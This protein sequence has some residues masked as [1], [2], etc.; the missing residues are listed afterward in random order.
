VSGSTWSYALDAT[1]LEAMGQGPATLTATATDAAGN[2]SVATSQSIAVDT[3]A[4]VVKGTAT[5]SGADSAG[6]AKATS[7]T[8]GDLLLVS[9]DMSEDVSVSSSPTYTITLDDGTTRTATYDAALSGSAELVFSYAVQASDIDL[10]GGVTA[11]ANALVASAIDSAGNAAN[12]AVAAIEDGANTVQIDTIAASVTNA[13]L[14]DGLVT[15]LDVSSNIVLT[16]GTGLTFVEGG[17]ISLVNDANTL[18]KAGYQGEN[19]DNTINLFLG[20]STTLDGITE[21]QAYQDV[22]RTAGTES[23]TVTIND[24]T[25]VVTI[26]PLYDFD[27][28]NS[29][30]VEIAAGTVTKTSNGLSNAAFGALTD[31]E[32]ALNFST[33]SPGD[34]TTSG[35]LVAAASSFTMSADGAAMESAH[36]WAS[37]DIDG[38]GSVTSYASID[39]GAADYALVL[40]NTSN[41]SES[42][43]GIL[44]LGLNVYFELSNFADGDMLYFDDQN[45]AGLVLFDGNAGVQPN[46]YGDSKNLA[47]D[48]YETIGV[49]AGVAFNGTD[50]DASLD[51]LAGQVIVA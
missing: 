35:S 10:S 16:F 13:A 36:Q 49:I 37:A 9:V 33:V 45:N 44:S 1:D 22:G 6:V 19:T 47:Y 30:H 39:V 5:I 4:P 38:L 17:H 21:I 28:S 50:F 25:G 27:L 42:A 40:K 14:M 23:G 11:T 18:A 46:G 51:A 2:T 12:I 7:L 41:A 29:Y 43:D 24:A 20:E 31:G 48:L 34:V 26:N 32:Y 8:T 3:V 15:N